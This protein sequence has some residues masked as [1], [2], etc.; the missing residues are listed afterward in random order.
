MTVEEYEIR[1]VIYQMLADAGV[2]RETLKDLA[3][4]VIEEKAE[5]AVHT[6]INQ[7]DLP[8]RLREKADAIA[9]RDMPYAV[10]EAIGKRISA[11]VSV[12]KISVSFDDGRAPTDEK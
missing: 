9:K 11:I 4:K 12:A 5:K 7:M 6:A 3:K 8:Q 2:N 10:R 1:K